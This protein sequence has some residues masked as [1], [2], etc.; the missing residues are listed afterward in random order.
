MPD[1]EV[2]DQTISS[3]KGIYLSKSYLAAPQ[4]IISTAQQAS[5]NVMGHND[6]ILA[7]LTTLS[8]LDTTNSAVLLV[9]RLLAAAAMA[10]SYV[11]VRGPSPKGATTL[12]AQTTESWHT[13][14]TLTISHYMQR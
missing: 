4:C 10:A 11:C 14:T 8:T 5:P 7:Q 1:I 2:H 13:R 3:S 6:P 12:G 9:A